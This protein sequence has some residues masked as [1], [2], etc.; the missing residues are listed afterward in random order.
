MPTVPLVVAA[1][2]TDT[3]VRPTVT[4]SRPTAARTAARVTL[5]LLRLPLSPPPLSAVLLPPPPPAN[6]FSVSPMPQPLL[7]PGP[8]VFP[9]PMEAVELSLATQS[10]VTGP[11]AAAAACTVTAVT[12][13]PTAVKV[14]RADPVSM[15][16]AFPPPPPALRL[17]PLSLEAL[18]SRAA[19]VSRLCTLVSCPT[20]VL[21]SWT[22]SRTTPR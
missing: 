18:R 8:L 11:K 10:A 16:L 5:P 20:V 21:Y 13:P 19:L 2:L 4:A 9:P 17:L 6:L 15:L 12:P 14:A 1:R 7:T 3:A 22:R